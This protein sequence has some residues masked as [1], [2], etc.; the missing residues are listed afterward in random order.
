MKN[1]K[2]KVISCLALV[3]A[4]L[5]TFAF[6]C[7]LQ[8]VKREI[9]DKFVKVMDETFKSANYMVTAEQDYSSEGKN[10]D[11]KSAGVTAFAEGSSF[12]AATDFNQELQDLTRTFY[13]TGG[14]VPLTEDNKKALNG[15]ALSKGSPFAAM[16]RALADIYG[17]SVF[18]ET[19]RYTDADVA[20]K[21]TGN[22]DKFTVN[23][24]SYTNNVISSPLQMNFTK[25]ADGT[26][27]YVQIQYQ[28]QSDYD[29]IYLSSFSASGVLYAKLASNSKMDLKNYDESYSDFKLREITV[30]S[31]SLENYSS[32]E[33]SYDGSDCTPE[34]VQKVMAFAKSQLGFT[35]DTYKYLSEVQ[36]TKTMSESDVLKLA[37][38]V[39]SSYYVSPYYYQTNTSFVR[40]EY[41]VPSDVTVIKTGSIPATKKIIL[42]E[43]VTKIESRPFQQPNYLEE[44][45]FPKDT[46]KLKEI[47]SFNYE[48]GNP[49]FILSM[50][51]VKNFVLPSSVKKL[52]LG[53]YVLNT[54]VELLD[55]SAYNPEWINDKNK[56][57][58]EFSEDVLK[59]DDMKNYYTS[60][61]K[62]MAYA[63][64]KIQGVDFTY[65][66]L[67][68]IHTLKMPQFNMGITF[69]EGGFYRVYDEA[70]KEYYMDAGGEIM[71]ALNA[72]D[73]TPGEYFSALNFTET[74]EVIDK[75]IVHDNNVIIDYVN[76]FGVEEGRKG[77]AYERDDVAVDFYYSINGKFSELY[78]DLTAINQIMVSA[79]DYQS[80]VDEEEKAFNNQ[81]ELKGDRVVI[82]K[83]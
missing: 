79:K 42:H 52:E 70:G 37:Q 75:V 16:A 54:E 46:S 65:Q 59:D 64:L 53:E 45:V 48:N 9:A 34:M 26:Y 13:G 40:D 67:R 47:G 3:C 50:T 2:I 21:I 30:A 20:F 83:K 68:Y 25:E 28:A 1:R 38:K 41:V 36:P 63:T 71:K 61:I 11:K 51:K 17:D 57:T 77:H 22:D 33:F 55:L 18:E 5:F 19:Y 10:P 43:N 12:S 4:L 27:S 39:E 14:G 31:F 7:N 29:E 69:E 24:I 80:F 49:T 44:I 76:L 72:Y 73:G 35:N 15:K 56:V 32:V 66:E 78:G 74:Y 6:G 81:Y 8:G 23:G 62:D 60:G 82:N 58:Y